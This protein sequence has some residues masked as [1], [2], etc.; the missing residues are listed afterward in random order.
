MKKHFYVEAQKYS[1]KIHV[2]IQ[3]ALTYSMS[4]TICGEWISPP[5]RLARWL[6]S[7]LE[8]RVYNTIQKYQ[9]ICDKKNKALVSIIEEIQTFN[10]EKLLH[11]KGGE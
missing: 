3:R 6:G 8:K 4:T 2:R 10:L 1:D 7:T 5:C 9:K 11:E